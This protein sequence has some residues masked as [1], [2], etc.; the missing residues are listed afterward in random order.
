MNQLQEIINILS[1]GNE[2]LTNALIKTKVF[3]YYTGNKDL[4]EW[5]NNEINGY[6]NADL[7]PEYRTVPA[8]I[9][10]DAHNSAMRYTSFALPLHHLSE[11][12]Y[13][14]TKISRVMLSISQIEKLTLDAGEN[15]KL[16]QPISIE[17]AYGKYGK[18]IDRSY[19]ITRCFKEIQVHSFYGILTQVRSRLLDFLLE[20]S[21]KA[22]EITG[23]ESEDEKLKK[24]DAAPLFTYAIYGDN[25]VI[26][27][28]D[29]NVINSTKHITKNDFESLKKY[30][31]LQGIEKDDI[32]KLK[33]AIDHDGPIA[34]K[35]AS[36]GSEVSGWFSKMIGKAADSSWGVGVAVA[37]STLTSAFKKYYDLE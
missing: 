36:Y 15:G 27:H 28:G 16:E 7:L 13:E 1:S 24:V 21:D 32:N 23:E 6:D 3:L 18:S 22:S 17:M 4:A 25:N 2:G 37:S 34:S 10:I 31:Q 26:N 8:R 14:E 9:L 29:S 20:Y 35:N 33:I 12:E 30:L 19:E 5:V 11:E